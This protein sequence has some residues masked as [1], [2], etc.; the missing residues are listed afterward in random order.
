M[1]K[2]FT[3]IT[4]LLLSVPVLADDALTD[5]ILFDGSSLPTTRIPA[6]AKTNTGALV[7]FAD[8]RKDNNGDIGL[9]NIDI[10]YRISLDNGATWSTEAVA[11]EGS[12]KGA[13]P[14]FGYGD[15]AVVADRESNKILVMAASG[16]TFYSNCTASCTRSGEEGNYTYS[17]TGALGV[18]KRVGTYADGAITWGDITDMT[19]D[20][21]SLY[22]N[23]SQ[24]GNLYVH[25]AFFGSG[26]ICQSSRVKVGEYYRLYAAL[27][28]DRGSLVVY[29][30][31]FGD[32]WNCLGDASAQPAS[33][34][35][36]AKI[37]E[38]PNGDVLLCTKV[39]NG[40]GRYINIYSYTDGDETYSSGSW[41]TVGKL[42]ITAASCNGEILLIP[43]G[44]NYV[45]LLSVP[46]SS[47]RTNVSIYY[48]TLETADS[49]SVSD[50]TTASDWSVYQVS[51]TGSA[52]SSMVQTADSDI[53]FVYEE[54]SAGNSGY[55][56]II[57]K[58]IARSTFPET[59]STTET[60]EFQGFIGKVVT[61]KATG[62]DLKTG[63]KYAY[64]LKS[65]YQD[66]MPVFKMVN[67]EEVTSF[68]DYSYYWVVS[69]D[70]DSSTVYIST[71][72]G[73]GYIGYDSVYDY[74]LQ[75]YVKGGSVKCTDDYTLVFPFTGFVKQA[76]SSSST[77]AADTL[78]GY[79]LRF[80]HPVKGERY[81][82]VQCKTGNLNFYNHTTK[83]D[84]AAI[85]GDSW[86]TDFIFT[87]VA[88][89]TTRDDYGTIDAPKHF[90]WKLNL[91]RSDD[92]WE[93]TEGETRD[94][95]GTLKLPFAVAVPEDVGVYK[96]TEKKN[97]E[98]DIVGIEELELNPYTYP[99]TAGSGG[100]TR[101]NGITLPVGDPDAGKT[102]KILPRET[103]VLLALP[104]EEGD[105]DVRK[106]YYLRPMPAQ[107]IIEDT[108]FKGTLGSKTMSDYDPTT[109]PNIYILSKKHGRVAFYY[110]TS[111]KFG[112]N[113]AYYVYDTDGTRPA[114]LSFQFLNEATGISN[115]SVNTIEEHETPI[116]DLMG[117][118][119][120]KINQSGIYL[121]NGKKFLVK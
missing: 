119:V 6:I 65:T 44:D 57:F 113:K 10:A 12:A 42:D 90:G 96:V 112:A 63:T 13:S 73:D 86:T 115:A 51:S 23:S 94:Y 101:A 33:G 16:S 55:Y 47:S 107:E 117:R 37:E 34:G 77:Y 9:S 17:V 82:A 49:Y 4:T 104:H 27:T 2:I 5:N 7:A 20:V 31:D 60:D 50:F 121:K 81:I 116:Y 103:P 100:W 120:L 3:L 74:S 1:K 79:A 67:A 25:R 19:N 83:S 98:N 46:A 54:T 102:F 32:T 36:E 108:G 15:A 30:D 38:L 92:S 93:L 39:Y 99:G 118:R 53:A 97:V 78:N 72:R 41:G 14:Y 88:Y 62:W 48:K 109:N 70:P 24:T 105:E 106:T 8:R 87:E 40:T 89:T 111:Q 52:Y 45:A 71:Y 80:N 69:Q 28:T 110:M 95:Y 114:A 59:T 91:T 22:Y 61:L 84:T 56:D 18:A 64:Y 21:Y 29:S 76:K 35:D 43:N 85:A 66:E 11:L 26:R 68:D 75:R 58:T